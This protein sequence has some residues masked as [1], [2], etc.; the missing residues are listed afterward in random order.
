MAR[1]K[2]HGQDLSGL[3]VIRSICISKNLFVQ[4]QEKKKLSCIVSIM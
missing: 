1:R 3:A 2:K 4:R